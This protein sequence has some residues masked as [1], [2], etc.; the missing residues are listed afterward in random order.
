MSSQMEKH[1]FNLKFSAKSLQR[2]SKRCEKEE[3]AEKMK[4][5]KAIQKGNVEGAKIHAENSIRNKNQALNMLRMSA[6]VDAVASRVQSAVAMKKVTSSM[7][8]VVK[9]M[10]SAMRSMNLEK[11]SALMEKFEKQFENLDVQSASMEETMSSSTTMSTP[12]ADVDSLMQQVADEAGLELNMEL[13]TGQTSALSMGASTA[14]QDELTQR[15]SKL[16]NT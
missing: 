14:E 15:L 7:A 3:K 10:D 9:S 16:R 11:V 5:K 8:G 2:E 12:Q 1:L 4:L 13:P 6:R